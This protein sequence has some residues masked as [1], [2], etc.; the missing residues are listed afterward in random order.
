MQILGVADG[1]VLGAAPNPVCDA[2]D[3]LSGVGSCVISVTVGAGGLFTVTASAA[4]LA[5]NL[6]VATAS[7]TLAAVCGTG[8]PD[9]PCV[10]P[11]GTVITDK[12][13]W[14]ADVLVLGEVTKKIEVTNGS[15]T[16]GS[17]GV[18]GGHIKQEGDGGVTVLAG[19]FVDGKIEESGAGSVAI[20]GTV[21]GN[22]SEEGAG[23]LT[24]EPGAYIDGSV[25]ESGP[26]SVSLSGTVEKDVEEQDDGDLT[27]SGSGTVVD[28]NVREQGA[29]IGARRGSGSQGRRGAGRR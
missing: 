13:D 23:D 28:G 4:D 18:V 11:Y 29:G 16:V 14:N 12:I 2:T 9:V 15:V 5:G 1:A 20:G 10:V 3:A 21:D 25:K 19:G 24:I 7:Y 22:V 6:S 27:I 17:T 26:G 8:S